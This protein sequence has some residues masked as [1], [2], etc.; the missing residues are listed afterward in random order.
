MLCMKRKLIAILLAPPLILPAAHKKVDWRAVERISPGT[1][2]LVTTENGTQCIFQKATDDALYCRVELPGGKS[3]AI[4]E[5][6]VFKRADVRG[7]CLEPVEVC[8]EFDESAGTL[9]LIGALQAGG[10]WT[11]GFTPSAFAGAKLGLGGITLDLQYDRI[12]NRNG[13]ST[14]GSWMIPVLRVPT[15]KQ[16]NDR[17]FFR[18][19]AEPG[20]GYRAGGV[21]FG[22]YAS[23]KALFLF[24]KKWVNG[25]GSPYIEL[26]R[27]F[28][29]NSPL[30]GDNRI[31]FGM[32]WA[33]CAQCGFN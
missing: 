22:Q 8:T 5:D 6:R 25:G 2:I 32:M 23:A 3:E 13:F 15:Y 7:L 4:S 12:E 20:L 33:V 17:L 31:A 28:P 26:Q 18:A 24:G 11:N 9:Q 19:Y 10:G 14:E 29:F 1:H 21:P 30:S 27:R 16:G